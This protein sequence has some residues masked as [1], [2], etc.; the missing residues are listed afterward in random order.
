MASQ[1]DQ[2]SKTVHAPV[3]EEVTL[4]QAQKILNAEGF[5]RVVQISRDPK[6]GHIIDL[7]LRELA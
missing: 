6:T 2:A 7:V 1:K 3:V 5:H 4:E